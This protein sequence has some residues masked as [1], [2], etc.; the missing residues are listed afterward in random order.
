MP[1]LQVDPE[2][3]GRAEETCQPLAAPEAEAAE[4]GAEL[5]GLGDVAANPGGEEFGDG[6]GADGG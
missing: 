2:P 3:L 5:E 6:W 1:R 4:V